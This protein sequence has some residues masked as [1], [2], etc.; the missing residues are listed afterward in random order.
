MGMSKSDWWQQYLG[1]KVSFGRIVLRLMKSAMNRDEGF[2]PS[3]YDYNMIIM[4]RNRQGSLNS[5][6]H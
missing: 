4:V 6:E 1:T 2:L 5:H 3:N